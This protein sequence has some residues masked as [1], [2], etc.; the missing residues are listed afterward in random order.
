MGASS[1]GKT[2]TSW[3]TYTEVTLDL[4]W[5][6]GAAPTASVRVTYGKRSFTALIEVKTGD[7]RLDKD[8][9]NEYWPSARLGRIMTT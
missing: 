1:A 6:V 7:N 4:E 8:Q 2:C 3:M 5:Q 9:I